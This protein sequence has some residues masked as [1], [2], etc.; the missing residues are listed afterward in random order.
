MILEDE[1]DETEE[2]NPKG[3]HVG[4]TIKHPSTQTGETNLKRESVGRP[5][6]LQTSILEFMAHKPSHEFAEDSAAESSN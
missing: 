5:T 6:G 3:K 1:D 4:A 2:T